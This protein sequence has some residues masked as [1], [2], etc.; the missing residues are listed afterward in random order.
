MYEQNPVNQQSPN[1]YQP[2]PSIASS[3]LRTPD[4]FDKSFMSNQ[5]GFAQSVLTSNL[6]FIES[7]I[8]TISAS[9]C[10][11][12]DKN[13]A[14][15]YNIKPLITIRDC[16]DDQ[17]LVMIRS[18]VEVSSIEIK[19]KEILSPKAAMELLLK[20]GYADSA[21]CQVRSQMYMH[22]VK[23]NPNL[24]LRDYTAQKRMYSILVQSPAFEAQSV[25]ISTTGEV[26]KTERA[27]CSQIMQELSGY[28]LVQGY[29]ELLPTT[30][31]VNIKDGNL[32]LEG[33]LDLDIKKS[34]RQN[35]SNIIDELKKQLNNKETDA[36]SN[37]LH[38][39]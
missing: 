31:H 38:R 5:Q 21:L 7:S 15:Q 10:E 27:I 11:W 32:L 29:S 23:N 2:D 34:N 24:Q 3:I 6:S 9:L 33:R 16:A 22:F 18:V 36:R 28:E 1:P 35:C 14:K 12:I 19:E 39:R 4:M 17:K 25:C 13:V 30:I 20:C 37:H 8:D 26:A